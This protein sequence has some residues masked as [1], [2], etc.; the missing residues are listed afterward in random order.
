VSDLPTQ[1]AIAVSRF[2]YGGKRGMALPGDP[3]DWLA[4]QLDRF[5]PRPQALSG[6]PDSVAGLAAF[7]EYRMNRR[8][9]RQSEIEAADAPK[10]IPAA[11]AEDR[12]ELRQ[13]LVGA[14]DARIALAA[15]TDTPFAE[16][17]VHFWANHFAVST[18]KQV[19]APLAGPFEAEAIRPHV[20]GRFADM[21]LAVERHPAMLLYFDQATSIGPNSMVGA[22]IAERGRRQAGLN[23]NL[24]REIMELHTLGVRSG[25]TQTDVTEFAR[26]LTGWTIEGVGRAPQGRGGFVFFDRAHEPGTRT[27]LG[28]QYP[29]GGEE[30]ARAVIAD[31]VARPATARHIAT[32]L[33]RHFVS[34]APPETLVAR[35]ERAFLSS[36]GDLPTVYRA[37]IDA[38]EAWTAERTKFLTP[39]EWIVASL[40]ATGVGGGRPGQSVRLLNQLGQPLWRPGSPAGYADVADSWAAPDALFRRIEMAQ[41]VAQR[42]GE[43]DAR[44]AAGELYPGVLSDTTRSALACAESPAQATA[45]LL[46]SPEA[47]W[48]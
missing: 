18:D 11:M 22:R 16:R 36:G 45:L 46:S 29:E 23:E 15:T 40:R 33:A 30:Q 48:R 32:K 35:L 37:L 1:Q 4:G 19:V 24:A 9:A 34:D 44:A 38:P 21:V 3:R 39:F 26:A 31:L 14:M 43:F 41:Q 5:D 25:Y 13:M 17:L 42:I 8:E 2:G 28:K 6:L 7:R 10:Q 12:H 20:M 27:I 47:M